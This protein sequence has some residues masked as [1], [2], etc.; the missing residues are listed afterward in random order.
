MRRQRTL[1]VGVAARF[2]LMCPS[3]RT[4]YAGGAARLTGISYAFGAARLTETLNLRGACPLDLRSR[5]CRETRTAALPHR[6]ASTFFIMY[7]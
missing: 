6:Y 7:A 3:L 2:A 4:P 5:L 1:R